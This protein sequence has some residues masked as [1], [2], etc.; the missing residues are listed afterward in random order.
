LREPTPPH[1]EYYDAVSSR[2]EG[3]DG[4]EE[5]TKMTYGETEI[6]R[7]LFPMKKEKTPY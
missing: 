6:E 5:P 4:L 7:Q 2:K 3:E 1:L